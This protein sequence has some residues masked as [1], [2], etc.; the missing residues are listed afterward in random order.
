MGEIKP[1]MLMGEIKP[2]MW[3]DSKQNYILIQK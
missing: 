1:E 2:E 3:V